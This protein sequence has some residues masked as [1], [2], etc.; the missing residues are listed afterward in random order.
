M[1]LKK[2]FGYR[3]I[4]FHGSFHDDVAVVHKQPSGEI[5]YRWTQLDHIYDFLVESG[6]DPIVELNP[7][8]S[9]LASGDAT[10]SRK[11]APRLR[12]MATAISTTGC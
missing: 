10:F 3:F 1:R 11:A 9:A 4:R 12:P 8:P 7:M 6:F 5:V 2:E